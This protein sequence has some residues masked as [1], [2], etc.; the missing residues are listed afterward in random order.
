MSQIY[1]KLLTTIGP[2]SWVE[3]RQHINKFTVSAS[4]LRSYC[5]NATGYSEGGVNFEGYEKPILL[6]ETYN[7]LKNYRFG[8]MGKSSNFT[9]ETMYFYV[10]RLEYVTETLTRVY[11]SPNYYLMYKDVLFC[12]IPGT[13]TWSNLDSDSIPTKMSYTSGYVYERKFKFINTNDIRYIGL[14]YHDTVDNAN[15]DWIYTFSFYSYSLI[16]LNA[17]IEQL[18]LIPDGITACQYIGWNL[19]DGESGVESILDAGQNI[20]AQRKKLLLYSGGTHV[21]A[22]NISFEHNASCAMC[23]T[24]FVGN[25][26]WQSKYHLDIINNNQRVML[27][28][29][30]CDV[31]LDGFNWRI[32][33]LSDNLNQTNLALKFTIPCLDWPLF[34]DTYLNYLI[35]QRPFNEELRR[36]QQRYQGF[37]SVVNIANSATTGAING[38]LMGPTGSL[39]GGLAGVVGGSISA[40]G[41]TVALKG[42]NENISMVEDESYKI[43]TDMLL[44]ASECMK[45]MIDSNYGPALYKISIDPISKAYTYDSGIHYHNVPMTF[46]QLKTLINNGT[47]TKFAGVWDLKGG[48]E[49]AMI[50]LKQLFMNGVVIL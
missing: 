44:F 7:N 4:G 32:Q 40:L 36:A 6:H 3:D 34:S 23:V 41:S 37:S 39:I 27:F 33:I 18:G 28:H 12:D 14:I 21:M 15:I 13:I 43:G 38:A 22:T 11:I 47:I 25:V 45:T 35:Q 5:N 50:E 1:I 20:I 46:E 30:Y 31:G 49:S 26:V 24:D 9:T 19:F 16:D 10:D 29:R 17:K 2:N 42:Y 8:I 48:P